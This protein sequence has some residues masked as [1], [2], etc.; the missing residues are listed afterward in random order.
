MSTR[1][2]RLLR[3]I[4]ATCRTVCASCTAA[5]LSPPWDIRSRWGPRDVVGALQVPSH[6][7]TNLLPD[8]RRL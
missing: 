7:A 2:R 3:S 4:P 6:R 1:L 5:P 8:F